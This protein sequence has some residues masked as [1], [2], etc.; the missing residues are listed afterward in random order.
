[1][2]GKDYATGSRTA[3]SSIQENYAYDNVSERG[4]RGGILD[5]QVLEQISS[6]KGHKGQSTVF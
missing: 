3:S 6:W 2:L 4:F 5:N 1:M